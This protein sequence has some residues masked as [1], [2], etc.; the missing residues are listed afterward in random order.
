[1]V[2]E[3]T[4]VEARHGFSDRQKRV[5][6][7]QGGPGTGKSVLAANLLGQL[8]Q[9]GLHAQYATGSRAFTETLRRIVGNRAAA[10]FTYFNSY[11]SAEPNSV[12]VLVCDEAHRIREKSF[13]QYTPATERNAMRLQIDEL[14][15][16]AKVCVFFIDDRQI[17]RPGEIG[18]AE[19][20]RS[21]AQQIGAIVW[22]YRLEAQF[23]CAGSDGFVNWVDNTLG[24]QRT[25]NQIWNARREVFDF[26]VYRTVEAFDTAINTRAEQGATARLVAGFCWPWSQPLPDGTLI[27]DVVVGDFRRPWNAKPDARRLAH[28]IPKSSH[29]A[30]EAGGLGQIGCIYTAQGFEFDYVGVI[31]GNDLRY[32]AARQTWVAD[33]THSKDNVVRRS[34]D[35]FESLVR[36]TYR[37]LLS[38]GLKGCYVYC[39][40]E[41][42][43]K[44]LLSRTEGLATEE[45]SVD[46]PKDKSAPPTVIPLRRLPPSERKPFQ[47]CI[48]VYELRFAAGHF[49]EF[50]IPDPDNVAWVEPPSGRRPTMDLFIAQVHGESMNRLVPNGAWCLFR[51]NPAG[52]RNGKIVVVQL[53]DYSDPDTGAA[54][55]V[56]RYESIKAQSGTNVLIRLKPE[57]TMPGYDAIEIT[58]DEQRV[59]V[60]AELLQVLT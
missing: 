52:T 35:A 20:I 50:Q 31:W 12:D 5:L 8:S 10:Q 32:D 26:R 37:V 45:E 58:P 48:P 55:T 11:V 43:A 39:Q 44:F 9:A 29:W 15:T 27:A 1:V 25:A 23:R 54:F 7:V 36:N 46:R 18:S 41:E 38:R 40:D 57:S 49:G 21:K 59:R 42:T 30:Y 16:A 60:I 3:R 6:L 24:V 47:N 22:D 14:L 56:K 28:G 13:S 4:L 19:L 33:R 2:F 53:S 17:V 51:S 34:R